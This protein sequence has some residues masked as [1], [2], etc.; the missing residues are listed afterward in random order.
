MDRRDQEIAD[1]KSKL[2]VLEHENQML[3]ERAE[4]MSLMS[5][6]TE[7]SNETMDHVR[8]VELILERVSMLKDI[9]LCE[10]GTV[11][12]NRITPIASF[13]QLEEDTC[14]KE[15]IIGDKLTEAL[16]EG[17]VYL[18]GEDISQVKF[19]ESVTSLENP[20]NEI[21]IFTFIYQLDQPAVFIFA[22]NQSVQD[23]QLEKLIPLLQQITY[24]AEDR[25]NN[26]FLL[27][28][29][30][31]NKSSLEQRVAER[32]SELE[33]IND[34]LKTEIDRRRIAESELELSEEKFREIFNHANDAM[35]LWESDHNGVPLR[36]L[37]ANEVFLMMTGYTS[38]EVLGMKADTIRGYEDDRSRERRLEMIEGQDKRRFEIYLR[39]KSGA[40]IPTEV[41]SRRFRI[42]NKEVILAVHRDISERKVFEARIL[43][44]KRKAEESDRLKSVFLANMSHEIRTPMNAIVG[45]SELLQRDD[46]SDDERHSFLNILQ[47]KSQELLTLIN[48]ILYLSRI[49][50]DEVKIQLE[51][52]KLDEYLRMSEIT[53]KQM[54][55]AAQKPGISIRFN[56]RKFG[57]TIVQIDEVRVSQVMNNLISNA[58]K[59]TEKGEI[60]VRCEIVDQK[61]KFAVRDTG[62]G[63][64]NAKIRQVFERFRQGD[65]GQSRK[66]GG[67]GLGLSI[68]KQ[69]VELMGGEI[70]V[71]SRVG[72]GSEFWFTIPLF[73]PDKQK[74]QKGVGS[75]KAPGGI[76]RGARILIVED[77]ITNFKFLEAALSIHDL[78]VL[79]AY[80]AEDAIRIFREDPG[81]E[82]VLM[83]LHLPG[84]T[85]DRAASVLKEINPGV[86]VIAQTAVSPEEVKKMKHRYMLDD[87]IFK[88]INTELLFSKLSKYLSQ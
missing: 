29:L 16:K 84:M 47:A 8:M 86:P 27:D 41:S 55:S 82:V 53:W 39:T 72:E 31:K 50:A 33:K 30:Q 77:E 68:S 58:I 11:D 76:P 48:D 49:E 9:L 63:I 56:Y 43:E 3:A 74:N 46:L 67:S 45:F 19:C 6:L 62:I 17:S 24:H 79:H 71:E 7:I 52:V 34:E 54:I 83:D 59:F 69:L 51:P 36:C 18:A 21:L 73:E 14:N 88:P 25:I 4:D 66:Y 70:G 81:I 42:R 64:P 28:A 60:A 44:E 35:I 78:Q 10:C 80:D 15:I 40:Q 57:D 2:E 20:V 61:I 38:E 85:G 5:M 12:G 75:T 22:D 87:Y 1:L 13:W 65:E 26:F 32:T 23:G 37:D